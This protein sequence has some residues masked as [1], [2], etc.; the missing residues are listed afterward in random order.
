[1][2]RYEFKLLGRGTILT[3]HTALCE[4]DQAACRRGRAYLNANSEFEAVVVSCGP[5]F[6]R[7][8]FARGRNGFDVLAAAHAIDSL[9]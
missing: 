4:S 1:M 8:L 7:K 5:R 2:A 6:Q 9:S 3:V